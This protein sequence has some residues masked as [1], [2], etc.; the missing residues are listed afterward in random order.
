MPITPPGTLTSLQTVLVILYFNWRS[1]QVD[2][3][4]DPDTHNSSTTLVAPAPLQMSRWLL[5]T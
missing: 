2:T 4:N 3:I 5:L 1:S